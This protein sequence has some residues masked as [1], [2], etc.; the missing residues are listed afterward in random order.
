M[1]KLLVVID[2]QNDFISGALG[3]D[4]AKTIVPGVVTKIKTFPGEVVYTRD[5]H[6]Q[7]YLKTQEGMNLPVEHCI[8]GTWG[9][10]LRDEIKSLMEQSGSKVHNKTTFGSKELIRY[11][12]EMSSRETIDEIELVGLCTDICV[13]SNALGIKAF[14]PEVKIT[15]DGSCCAGVTPESHNHA[16]QAM[17]MC[18]INV[19]ND[20]DNQIE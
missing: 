14:L 15:V 20:K 8:Q 7:N 9:W 11:L 18:H 10:E 19:I 2:M 3:S 5:T 6:Q 17:K 16:L 12:E 13:I 1:K 4:Q